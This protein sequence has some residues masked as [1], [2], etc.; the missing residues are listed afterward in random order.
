MEKFSTLG[1]RICWRCRLSIAH[2]TRRPAS[3][4]RKSA[5]VKLPETP[6]RTRFAPSPTGSLHLGSLRTALFNYLLAR[7]TKGQFLLRLEDTDR[8]RTV[9]GAEQSL[10]NDLKWAGLRWDEG[11][12]VGGPYGPYRQSERKDTYAE[13]VQHLL[14]TGKAYRCFCSPEEL[15]AQ[16]KLAHQDGKQ[17]NYNGTCRHISPEES[18]ERAERG[19]THAVRFMSSQRPVT[20][21]DLV[22]NYYKKGVR[23]DDFIIMKRDGYPTYHF[24]NVVDD[25]LMDITHV[26]RGAVSISASMQEEEAS[27]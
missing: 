23:E 9:Q 11:P 4:G 18:A 12:D 26:I 17:A 19:D 3:S 16:Q 24:A 6:C 22:Y 27:L 10:Y 1:V 13:K 7:A 5:A 25:H 21:Q 15:E 8:A 20:Y 14:D 2:S